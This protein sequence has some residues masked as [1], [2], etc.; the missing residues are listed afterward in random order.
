MKIEEN[1]VDLGKIYPN[2][3]LMRR[4]SEIVKNSFEKV[5][6]KA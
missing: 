2:E 3:A 4:T 6:I 1:T 5:S